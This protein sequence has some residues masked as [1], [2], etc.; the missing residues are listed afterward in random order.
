[1]AHKQG[2]YGAKS[3][4][5]SVRSPGIL[6]LVN[7]WSIWQKIE[8]TVNFRPYISVLEAFTKCT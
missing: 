4:V 3:S 8:I 2:K 6:T 7:N 5:F 1:M